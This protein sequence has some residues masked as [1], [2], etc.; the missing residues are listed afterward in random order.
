MLLHKRTNSVKLLAILLF[1]G[2]YACN[3]TT[4]NK[5]VTSDLISNPISANNSSEGELPI[6]QFNKVEHDFGIILQGEK[7]AYTFRVKNIGSSDLIIN[8]AKASCG[9]TV[10]RYSK[11][12]IAPGE[13]GTI[14][15]I[16]NSEGRTGTQLKTLTV[17]SNCQPNTTKLSIISEIVIPNKK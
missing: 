16:F 2:L 1:V 9:C 7:V 15:V 17:W 3:N 6:A 12:P 8:N 13:E 14:E 5:A 4:S 11:N 10:P